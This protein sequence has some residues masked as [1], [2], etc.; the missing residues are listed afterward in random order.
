MSNPAAISILHVAAPGAIGG[1]ER[2]LHDLAIGRHRP[3]HYVHVAAL[4]GGDGGHGPSIDPLREAAVPTHVLS[5]RPHTVLRERSFI[6][7]I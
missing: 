4:I 1:L 5:I 7:S 3:G 6:R 2:V